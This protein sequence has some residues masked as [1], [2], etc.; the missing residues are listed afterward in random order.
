[1]VIQ[2]ER[3]YNE[4]LMKQY[5][6]IV[7]FAVLLHSPANSIGAEQPLAG[8][9]ADIPGGKFLMG[10]LSGDGGDNERPVH[11]VT[12]KPFRLG[13]YEI[14]FAQWDNCVKDGGCND[15]RPDD[16]GLG[17]GDWPVINVSWKDA[18]S[19]ITWLNKKTG[20]NYRLPSEAEWEY[21]AREGGIK[22]YSWGDRASHEYANYGK[23]ECCGKQAV[24]HE[25]WGDLAPVGQL[26]ANDFG[27]YD[28][29]GNVWEWAADCWH[30]T[31]IGAPANGTVWIQGGQCNLRVSRGGS[32]NNRPRNVRSASRTWNSLTFRYNNLGFRLAQDK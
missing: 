27:L 24:G 31:Y 8:E 15:Y 7:L 12:I 6:L 29:H 2:K 32:F 1:M 20:G 23:E 10:D 19:F 4:G 9:F 21:A 14:T 30:P 25:R 22:K 28:M 17:R 5:Q 26:P 18:Q 11:R 13:K 16:K 3:D